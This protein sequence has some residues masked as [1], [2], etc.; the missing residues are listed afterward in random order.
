MTVNDYMLVISFACWIVIRQ[1]TTG[2]RLVAANSLPYAAVLQ[3]THNISLHRN[4]SDLWS[5][6]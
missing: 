3:R 2:L 5:L 6:Y 1:A 4:S